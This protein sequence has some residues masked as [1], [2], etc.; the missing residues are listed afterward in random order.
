[1]AM[2]GASVHLRY[3]ATQLSLRPPRAVTILC[4]DADWRADALRM[5]ECY[6]RTWGGDGNGLVACSPDWKIAEPFWRL[7]R[8]FDADHWVVFQRTI[9]GL[10]LADPEA[11]E[12][13]LEKDVTAWT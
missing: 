11:Y 12:A 2:N 10:R 7:L 9:R 6:S 8:G 4:S 5:M 3:R 13:R 1:M